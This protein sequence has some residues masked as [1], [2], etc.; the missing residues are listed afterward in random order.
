MCAMAGSWGSHNRN[1]WN[2]KIPTV[3]PKKNKTDRYTGGMLT[4]AY[5]AG[6]T[7]PPIRDITIGQLLK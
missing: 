7:S 1:K 5:I 4:E 6:P 3:K 2:L